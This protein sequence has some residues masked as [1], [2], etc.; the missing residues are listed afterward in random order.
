MRGWRHTEEEE[1]PSPGGR[2]N[3]SVGG[4]WARTRRGDKLTPLILQSL[5]LSTLSGST[6]LTHLLWRVT[7]YVIVEEL[8]GQGHQ[9]LLR[10][11]EEN[12][13]HGF[14]IFAEELSSDAPQIV[15]AGTCRQSC[16][17]SAARWSFD[18]LFSNGVRCFPFSA[19]LLAKFFVRQAAR[20]GCGMF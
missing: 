3:D 10:R 4:S 7:K 11:S 14:P 17:C 6:F 1:L 2:S 13:A 5:Q 18:K 8:S 20:C 16:V 15:S 12:E 19:N 9:T